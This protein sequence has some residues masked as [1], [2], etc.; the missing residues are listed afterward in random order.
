MS[1]YIVSDT[2][3][4]SVANAIRTKGG[5]SAS[6]AFPA[7]FVQAIGDIPSGGGGTE[8]LLAE[9]VPSS[10]SRSISFPAG[11]FVLNPNGYLNVYISNVTG[12]TDYGADIVQR[13]YVI[14][15]PAAHYVHNTQAVTGWTGIVTKNSDTQ[16]YTSNRNSVSQS[17]TTITVSGAAKDF[18]AG[19]TY[20]FLICN[21]TE[22]WGD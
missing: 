6:L 9:V 19:K 2:D 4:T 8:H 12:N 11:D 18:R 17:G 14:Q 16:S 13:G 15:G 3:L 1:N 20:T 10:N 21:L 5:T 7:G 22:I